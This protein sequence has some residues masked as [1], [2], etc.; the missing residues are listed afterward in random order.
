MRVKLNWLKE[1][2]DLKGISLEELVDKL[3]NFSTEI[4]SVYKLLSGSKLTIG[5]VL[6]LSLIH[7]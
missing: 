5:H 3:S 7:I 2:V 1:L 4:E 6:S